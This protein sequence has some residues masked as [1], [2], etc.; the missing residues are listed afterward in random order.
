MTTPDSLSSGDAPEP[1]SITT[2]AEQLQASCSSKPKNYW[3]LN[4]LIV[5]YGIIAA[6]QGWHFFILYCGMLVVV[7]TVQGYNEQR[8]RRQFEL[9]AQLAQK[10]EKQQHRDDAH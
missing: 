4:L 6:L 7:F 9:L 10:L 2:L 8:M 1:V 3:R 5:C